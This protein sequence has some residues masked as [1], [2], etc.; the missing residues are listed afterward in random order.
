MET[1]M[2]AGGVRARVSAEVATKTRVQLLGGVARR[3]A[4]SVG[5]PE[6]NLVIIEQGI[7]KRLLAGF[8]VVLHGEPEEP[9]GDTEVGYLRLKIDWERYAAVLLSPHETNTFEIDAGRELTSQV[10]AILGHLNAYIEATCA[11]LPVVRR[12][13]VYT[14]RHGMGDAFDKEF[15]T[16]DLAED[17]TARL[18]EIRNGTVIEFSPR[19]LSELTVVFGHKRLD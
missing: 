13:V 11:R 12:Q 3:L 14:P 15:G 9:G 1:P 7:V 16:K 5:L 10:S 8:E 17:E 18:R 19:Q 6:R 4:G 2:S